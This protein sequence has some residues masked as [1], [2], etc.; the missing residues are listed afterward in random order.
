MRSI[1]N[2]MVFV[3]LEPDEAEALIAELDHDDNGMGGGFTELGQKVK[4]R[5]EAHNMFLKACNTGDEQAIDEA[6]RRMLELYPD[7]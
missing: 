4:D 3:G 7:K 6:D 2:E 5:I 1:D